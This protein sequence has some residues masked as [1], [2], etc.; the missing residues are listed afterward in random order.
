M[1]RQENLNVRI[2]IVCISFREPHK[3]SMK[4]PTLLEFCGRLK[5]NL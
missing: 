4:R 3:L 2:H 5:V 1:R